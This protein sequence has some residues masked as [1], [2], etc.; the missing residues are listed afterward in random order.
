MTRCF[1]ATPNFNFD[2]NN[3]T[4]NLVLRPLALDNQWTNLTFQSSFSSAKLAASLNTLP[5][6]HSTRSSSFSIDVDVKI[7][8]MTKLQA[9]FENGATVRYSPAS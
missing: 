7:D 5:R 2:A 9:E 3:A 4:I 8:S 6:C 1:D